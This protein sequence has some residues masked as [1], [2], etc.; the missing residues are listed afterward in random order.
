MWKEEVV[1]FYV[2]LLENTIVSVFWVMTPCCNV[3][4][5]QRFGRSCCLHHHPEDSEL[6]FIAVKILSPVTKQFDV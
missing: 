1:A 5:Y 4:A 6:S 2:Q 3:V